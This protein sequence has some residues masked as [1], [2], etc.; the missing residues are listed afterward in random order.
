MIS[1]R[2][3]K[4]KKHGVSILQAKEDKCCYLCMLLDGD[5]REKRVQEH[6]VVFGTANRA[7][8]EELGLKVNLCVDRHHEFGKEAVHNNH[9]NA[10]ILQREAQKIFER[11][12][13]HEE[14]MERIG[15]NYL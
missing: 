10:R 1:Q 7:V 5:H 14:W 4:R 8:S 13:S 2:K 9:E 3:K 15:R 6:H 11:T 12:H